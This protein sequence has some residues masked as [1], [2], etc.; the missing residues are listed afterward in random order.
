LAV[1]FLITNCVA[2]TGSLLGHVVDEKG[3]PV[4][5]AFVKFSHIDSIQVINSEGSFSFDYLPICTDTISVSALAY[6]PLIRLVEIKPDTIT[7]ADFR[8]I[9]MKPDYSSAVG[10][11]G[12][13]ERCCPP[14]KKYHKK[15]VKISYLPKAR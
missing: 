9:V 12:T 13:P 10:V 4:I 3:K 11:C 7:T 2:Q 6:H 8:L 15:N 14:P 1:F 5:G